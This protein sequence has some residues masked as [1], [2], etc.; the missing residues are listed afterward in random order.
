MLYLSNSISIYLSIYIYVYISD[1]LEEEKQ[2]L[3][4]TSNGEEDLL[5]QLEPPQPAEETEC[6][7][8]QMLLTPRFWLY[9]PIF[10]VGTGG[11]LL[12]L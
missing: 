9:F 5:R 1:S 12:V 4:H 6:N 8:I 11:G 2:G 10:L 7:V 3:L